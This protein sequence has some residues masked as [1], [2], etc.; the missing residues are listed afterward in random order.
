MIQSHVLSLAAAVALFACQSVNTTVT[1]PESTQNVLDKVMVM[2]MTNNYESRQMW[3]KEMAYRLKTRGRNT[4]TSVGIDPEHKK[5]YTKEELIEI[6]KEHQLNGILTL[7]LKDIDQKAGYTQSDR[8]L[9]DPYGGQIYM[10]NYLDPYMNVRGW[11]YKLDQKVTIE[12]KLFE[13]ATE[14]LVLEAESTMSNAE[15]NEALAGEITESLA[16][17]IANSR[18]LKQQK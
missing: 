7:R 6:V 14:K 16:K 10:Y 13:T 2:A 11:Q 1:R 18:L 12:A 5:F 9:S 15:S 4:I 3:E 17:S 8:Y